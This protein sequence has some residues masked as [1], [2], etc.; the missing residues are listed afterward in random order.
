MGLQE[1]VLNLT[2]EA[3]NAVRLAAFWRKAI[4]THGEYKATEF[5]KHLGLNHLETK[6]VEWEGLKLSREPKD[7]EK[8][9]VKGIAGA[10]E[11]AKEKI[12]GILLDLRTELISD[13]LKALKK[14]APAEYHT[15]T[16]HA[17]SDSRESLRDR[18]MKVHK[19]GRI[20]VAAELSK[21]KSN[22]FIDAAIYGEASRV[23]VKGRAVAGAMFKQD[24]EDEFDDLDTLTD[25]ST[26]RVTNDVQSRMVDAAA[27][28]TLL[29]LTGAALMSAI[30]DEIRTGSVTYIDRA[31]TGLANR[32]IN[33]GRNDE[34]QRRSSEWSRV[35]YSALL[36]VNT[37]D[38]CA[39]ADGQ[40]SGDGSDLDPVPNPECQGGDWCR[41]FWVYV[42][43]TTN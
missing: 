26:S 38:P 3:A 2:I 5:Y 41:C 12:S 39:A 37:C 14:L 15:L 16:L 20:L 30:Q 18:L 33:I 40:E 17:S 25:V 24:T 19:Q 42:S 29:G 36:D 31:S 9:A 21:G 13:G 34:A 43:D 32:V 28:F 23:E 1:K 8:I 11:S 6:S 35:E 10:Q 7:Y 4:E 22:E 27:R